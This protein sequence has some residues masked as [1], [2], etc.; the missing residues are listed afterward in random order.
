MEYSLQQPVECRLPW[1]RRLRRLTPR[2]VRDIY[3]LGWRSRPLSLSAGDRFRLRL[4][5]A[6]HRLIGLPKSVPISSAPGDQPLYIRPFT[7]DLAVLI[8]LHGSDEYGHVRKYLANAQSIIDLGANVGVSIRLWAKWFPEVHIVAV[9]PDLDNFR[10]ATKNIPAAAR[11]R[12]RLLHCAAHDSEGFLYLNRDCEPWSIRTKETASNQG[13]IKVA[14]VTLS[15]LIE[16]MPAGPIDLLKCDIEGAEEAVFRDC[17]S[18][19]GKIRVIIVETH[20]PYSMER[21]QEDLRKA[22]AAHRLV[23][24]ENHGE[25]NTVGLFVTPELSG[26]LPA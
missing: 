19:I 3:D 8:S 1:K 22:G 16:Q 9:E 14:T 10:L 25:K 6:C 23:W 11:E 4:A 26:G 17:E 5:A 18:W 12:V 7:S 13:A 24:R 15:Q 20:H 21:L 2:P